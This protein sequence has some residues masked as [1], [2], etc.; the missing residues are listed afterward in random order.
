MRAD[1]IGDVFDQGR[2]EIS[3]RSLARPFSYR[4]DRKIVVAVDAQRGN[5][6]AESARGKRAGAAARNALECRDRPLIIDDIEHDW[7]SVCRGE[8]KRGMEVGLGSG[9]VSDPADRDLAIV[10]DG[11]GHRPADGLDILGCKIAR[12]REEAVLPG[13]IHHGELASFQGIVRVRI[14]L[15][16]HVDQRVAIGD[17]QPGLPIGWK[18]HV[19]RDKRL[20]KGAADR[21]FAKILHVER[22]LALALRRLH[23]HVEGAQ[24]HHVA[25]TFEQFGF[26]QRAGPWTDGFG[27]AIEHADDREGEIA[28]RLGI[29]IDGR[30]IDRACARYG[31]VREVR[32]AAGPDGRLR[33][34]K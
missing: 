10:L 13:R 19:T 5:A 26:T 8:D 21:L 16:G 22:G 18:I 2:S 29:D 7:R 33:H 31:D 32:C 28:D 11:G 4:M 9:A 30:A 6:E 24:G 23:A 15:A 25:Q 1:A 27:F 3:P 20:A 14:N 17:Q 12:Y 34:M